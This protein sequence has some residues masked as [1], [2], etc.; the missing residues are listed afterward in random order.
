M[1]RLSSSALAGLAASFLLS[2]APAHAVPGGD[3]GTLE[4]GN[5]QCELPGDAS[6]PLR[7]AAPDQSFKVIGAS[8]YRN[9]GER[10][11]Y[12]LLGDDLRMTSGPLRGQRYERVSDGYLRQVNETGE[13]TRLRCVLGVRRVLSTAEEEASYP[14]DARPGLDQ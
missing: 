12:L 6:G 7:V 2:S 1:N 13:Q 4:R 14:S 5:Y 10:G 9:G 8:S 11:T 3:L